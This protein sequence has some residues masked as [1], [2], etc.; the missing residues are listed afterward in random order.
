MSRIF[1]FK[2]FEVRHEHSAMK[3]G[4]DSVLLGSWATHP[5]PRRILDAGAGCGVLALMAAQKFPEVSIA[6]IEI[7]HA[8]A[9]EARFNAGNSPFANRIEVIQSDLYAY[10]TSDLYDLILS[11]PPWFINSLKAGTEERTLARHV[12]DGEGLLNWMRKLR[13][14]LSENGLIATILPVD[15]HHFLEQHQAQIN[16]YPA[17]LLHI[18]SYA[19]TNS[20]RVL[21]HWAK[22]KHTPKV[23]EC[24]L[25]EGEDRQ[26]TANYRKLCKDFYL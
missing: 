6:A 4:T 19:H 11:N 9:E 26:R 23:E 7:E 20:I 22:E 25:Y 8:A 2:Q 21:A 13:E 15:T 10:K 1:R 16:L 17:S 24:V 5:E 3:V 12:S 18:K 14:L